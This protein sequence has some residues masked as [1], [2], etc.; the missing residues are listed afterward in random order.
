MSEYLREVSQEEL[1]TIRRR[2][3]EMI[4]QYDLSKLPDFVNKD[5][6]KIEDGYKAY[7][8]DFKFHACVNMLVCYIINR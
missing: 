7:H 1:D 6:F 3:I 8:D 2:V 5:Q 4:F